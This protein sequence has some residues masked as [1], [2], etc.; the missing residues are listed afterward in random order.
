LRTLLLSLRDELSHVC[1]VGLAILGGTLGYGDAEIAGLIAGA[2]LGLFVG[3]ILGGIVT[4]L[5]VLAF[6]PKAASE[7]RGYVSRTVRIAIMVVLLHECFWLANMAAITVSYNTGAFLTQATARGDSRERLRDGLKER[8]WQH[9][10]VAARPLTFLLV[11]EVEALNQAN[12]ELVDFA[13]GQEI[14]RPGSAPR[15][16]LKTKVI[17]A[18]W[19]ADHWASQPLTVDRLNAC[20]DALCRMARDEMAACQ[21]RGWI[22]GRLPTEWFQ[23]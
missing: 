23:Q 2:L 6:G 21:A 20:G 17:T 19:G 3:E 9:Q 11:D 12:L 16:I 22:L 8:R 10:V 15:D 1:G 18:L 5:L 13:N 14:D 7:R 4:N